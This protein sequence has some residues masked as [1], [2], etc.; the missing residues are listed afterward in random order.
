MLKTELLE[1]IANGE[2]SGIEFKRDDI[3][4]EDLGKEV[5]ALANLQGG[6]VLL[7]VD[8]DGT[9]SGIQDRGRSST[10]EWVMQCFRDKVHPLIIPYYE[11]IT[12]D[13]NLK[14]AIITIEQGTSKPYVL[15]HNGQERI[16]IRVGT[17]SR[18][19]TREQ[20]AR[21][22]GVGGLLHPEV[23]PV[24]GTSIASLD[25]DRVQNYL[26]DIIKDPER[27]ATEE[28]WIE[29]LTGLGFIARPQNGNTPCTIA[30][31]VS[32]G[33]APRRFLPQAGIRFMAF[34]GTDKT[35]QALI[36]EVIDGPLFNRLRVSESG[37]LENVDNGLIEKLS[38]MIRPYISLEGEAINAEMRRERIWLYPWEAVRETIINAIAHRDWTRSLDV[39]IVVYSDRIEITSPGAL[40]NS[41]TVEK[42]IAGQRSP[43]NPLIVG[44]L[45]DYGYVD[46]RGMG[47]R[48]KVI[49]LM[50][51]QN[52]SEPEF[53]ATDDYLKVTLRKKP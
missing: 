43:R 39:E 44:V 50:R 30:G 46:A 47:V 29:R 51:E 6:R 45:R 16:Y 18:D 42:M 53:Q 1:I 7:G 12:V 21:L 41:M 33:V 27:P 11:E 20:Q 3:R 23:M 28:Q 35:Y 38:T 34:E 49:P 26:F 14:V 36:D 37:A 5:V 9:I 15:R 52:Q 48:T 32:F 13:P 8:D 31:L 10:E 2:N 40:Q 22:Y 25:M 24:S 17:T 4:P 19:A